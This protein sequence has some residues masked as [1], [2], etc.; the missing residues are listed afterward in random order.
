M[1]VYYKDTKGT[2][3]KRWQAVGIQFSFP[4]TPRRDMKPLAKI[5]VRGSDEWSYAQETTLKN[6]NVN[7]PRGS[8]NYLAPYPL[9]I[10]PQ[11]STSLSRSFYNRDRLSASYIRQHPDRLREAWL[12]YRDKL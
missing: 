5:Q 11:P 3:Q 7:S 9:A 4:L 6:N 2:D 1:S 12:K 8:L 10:N